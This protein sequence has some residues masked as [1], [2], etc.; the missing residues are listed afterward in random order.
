[1]KRYRKSFIDYLHQR[2]NRLVT[3]EIDSDIDIRLEDELQTET[4]QRSLQQ[5]PERVIFLAVGM[6][7]CKHI[8]NRGGVR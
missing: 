1:M 8:S 2:D 5:M 4:V 3:W 7:L 6:V